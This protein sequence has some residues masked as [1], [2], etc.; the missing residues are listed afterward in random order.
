MWGSHRNRTKTY[1]SSTGRSTAFHVFHAFQIHQTSI[2]T[3]TNFDRWRTIPWFSLCQ[4]IT[5]W[6]CN[7]KQFSNH[8][9]LVLLDKSGVVLRSDD[10]EPIES[11]IKLNENSNF[12]NATHNKLVVAT[13]KNRKRAYTNTIGE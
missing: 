12:F 9:Q 7:D 2:L 1:A 8:V 4:N 13:V 10:V 6:N 5:N 11:R 3:N